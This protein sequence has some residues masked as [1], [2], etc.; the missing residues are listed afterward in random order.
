MAGYYPAEFKERFEKLDYSLVPRNACARLYVGGTGCG[1]TYK[2]VTEHPNA[3]IAVPTRQ[4]AYEVYL[5]YDQVDELHTGEVHITGAQSCVCVYENLSARMI[6]R[7]DYLIVDEA[8]F[9]NDD[10]RGVNLLRHIIEALAIGL[11]VILLTATDTIS[12]ELKARLNIRTTALKPFKKVE[13]VELNSLEQVKELAQEGKNI[14][15]FT[16]YMPSKEDVVEYADL[17]GVP[18]EKSA[19]I[20]ANVPTSERVLSQIRFKSGDIQLMVSTNVLAQ[21]CN[22]PADIVIIEYNE[23][24]SWELV[25]QKIG[26]AGRPNLCDK[27]YFLLTE[28]PEKY[29]A[30]GAPDGEYVYIVQNF[31]GIDVSHLRL[32][33]HEVPDNF[34]FYSEFKYSRKL[35]EYLDS[36]GEIKEDEAAAL[37]FLRDEEQ[38]LLKIIGG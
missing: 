35:L 33:S 4:L 8:H 11:P 21:G 25:N 38:K 36:I 27:G 17:L 18:A 14:L 28:V 6:E 13:K 16:K 10:E 24:D 9:I 2:A 15:V 34:D 19:M 20:S 5:D 1:K 23:Y 37:K 26:R 12:A 32:C 29:Q 22:F 7:Y 3:L 30:Q 31:R